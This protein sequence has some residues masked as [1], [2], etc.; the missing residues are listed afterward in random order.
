MARVA[1][2]LAQTRLRRVYSRHDGDSVRPPA[3]FVHPS[4]LSPLSRP[5]CPYRVPTAVLVPHRCSRVHITSSTRPLPLTR[6]PSTPHF[7]VTPVPHVPIASPVSLSCPPCSLPPSR[8]RYPLASPN[9]P[10]AGYWL[11]TCMS[12]MVARYRALRPQLWAHSIS[13]RENGLGAPS[14]FIHTARW[15]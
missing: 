4:P 9:S 2:N 12:Y 3:L 1:A 6:A 5:R 15:Q 8:L 14:T 10:T 7:P 11:P 13:N